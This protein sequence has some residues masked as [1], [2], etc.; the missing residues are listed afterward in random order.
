MIKN[1]TSDQTVD[2][3]AFFLGANQYIGGFNTEESL[4]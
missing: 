4:K 3:I 2:F 1:D